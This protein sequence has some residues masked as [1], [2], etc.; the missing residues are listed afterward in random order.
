MSYGAD[1][2]AIFRRAGVYLDKILKGEAASRIFW[3]VRSASDPEQTWTG[4]LLPY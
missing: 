2:R 1:Q 4:H 3:A